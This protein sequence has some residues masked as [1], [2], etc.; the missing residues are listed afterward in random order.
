[1]SSS[2]ESDVSPKSSSLRVGAA[3]GG[4]RVRVGRARGEARN[5]FFLCRDEI[6][7]WTK[8]GH[9][10]RGATAS[11]ENVPGGRMGGETGTRVD[12]RVNWHGR[13]LPSRDDVWRARHTRGRHD[14]GTPD[15]P[16][17]MSDVDA[18][19]RFSRHFQSNG[20]NI[21]TSSSDLSPLSF[22]RRR[23][24]SLLPSPREE[25]AACAPLT[26]PAIAFSPVTST[27]TDRAARSSRRRFSLRVRSRGGAC[28]A[29]ASGGARPGRLAHRPRAG[30]DRPTC[31]PGRARS[32][33]RAHRGRRRE[34]RFAP[35]GDRCGLTS[36]RR[37]VPR[38]FFARRRRRLARAAP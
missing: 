10:K 3:G 14:E 17:R 1:M 31:P 34:P 16:G 36:P 15:T 13:P 9:R 7:R 2:S 33:R 32:R 23:R 4:Q 22:P 35:I 26:E 12:V 30:W 11:R 25:N 6:L 38:G 20:R 24:V 37:G 5:G 29:S 27:A 18:R 21:F 8:T 19:G 28:R